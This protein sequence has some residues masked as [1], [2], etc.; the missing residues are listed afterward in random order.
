MKKLFLLAQILLISFSVWSQYIYT[1]F[2]GNEPVVFSG[3]PNS[4]IK[5]ANPNPSGIN[6]SANA[7]KWIRTGE[8]WAHVY[9]DLAGPIDFTTGT[10]FKLK[11][12]SPIPCN[13]LF[14]LE[15]TIAPVEI[16][17]SVSIPNQ[18][19]QLSYDFTGAPSGVYNKIVIFFDFATT[20][21]NT[22]YFDDI[23]G[24]EFEGATVPKPYLALDVQDN[25]ENN[26]W[27]SITEW[28]FQDPSLISLPVVADP[29]LPPNHVVDYDR[30]GAFLYTNAQCVL[31][32]RM[33]LTTRS[34]F[35]LKVFFPSSNNYSGPLTPTAALKLQN[36]LLGGNAWTTQEE[37][38]LPV[39]NF[40]QW[41]TL[42]FDFGYA[43]ARDDLDQV[44]IQLGGEGHNV[45]GQFYFD[46]FEL[47]GSPFTINFV[48]EN[49]SLNV[50]VAISPTIAFSVPVE[51]A[52]GN[53][54]TNSNI[55]SII[56]F[57]VN[58][59]GGANVP[60][61]GTVD[62]QKKVITINPNSDLSNNQT[63]YL[64]LNNEV[65]RYQ[66]GN[67][68]TGESIVF[69]TVSSTQLYLYDNFDDP[70]L[71]TWGYWD[72]NAG[73]I[74]DINANNPNVFSPLNTTATVAKYTKASGSDPYTHAFAIL[75]GKLDLSTNHLFQTMVYSENAGSVF[76]VKL[77]NN[78]LPE[79]WITEVTA[80]YTIQTSNTWEVANFD[81]SSYAD[82][83]DLDKLLLMINPGQTGVG[84][85]YFD[86]LYGPSFTLPAVSPV[87]LD[88]HI[89]NNGS[90]IEIHFD[91]AMEP[92]PLNSGN[93]NVSVDGI[94]NFVNSTYRK[95]EDHSI[96][97]LNLSSPVE[98]GNTVLLSYLISGTITSLDNGILQAFS[99]YPVFNDLSLKLN[100]TVFLEGPFNNTE[101]ST[102]LN[103]S[104]LPLNQ[105]Y[106][107]AP[108][109]YT[110]NESVAVIPSPDIVDWILIELRDAT[111][112][113]LAT[114]GK[115]IARQ[116]AFLLKNGAVVDLD[117]NTNLLIFDA[118][119]QYGLYVVVWHR[120]HIGILS[121]FQV[122]ASNGIYSYNFG[123]GTNQSFGNTQKEIG[124]N[125]WGMVAGNGLADFRIDDLDQTEV[126]ESQAGE[127]GYLQGDY[128]MDSQVNNKDKDDFW[129]TNFGAG[130]SDYQLIWEDNFDTNGA[131]DPNKWSYDFGTGANGWGNGELQYYTSLPQNVKVENGRL[132][133]T[134]RHESYAGSNYTSGRIKTQGK[135][136][137]QYGRVDIKT[138]LP[139]GQGIWPANWMLGE[140]FSTIGWP[141]C[142]EIDIMEYR[143][144]DPNIIH[145]AIHTPSS[146][147][148]TINHATT[149]IPNVENEFHIYSIEWDETKIRFLVDN[150][151]FY[152]YQPTV[153]NSSTWPF[154]ANLFLLLNL[155]VGGSFGGSVNNAIFPQTMEIDYIKV[156]Q[157]INN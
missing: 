94:M 153:Y 86:E 18:W 116:A 99:N 130:G 69:S 71:L 118:S 63:Y 50:P 29:I 45:P 137:F 122:I 77:Q 3:Y 43:Y 123:S 126:W 124:A 138:K 9:K 108:W 64:A 88:A 24:P 74:L 37:I 44:V 104:K 72:N 30:S 23:E 106:S 84:V 14:K 48:P 100:L 128:N 53:A 157:R 150:V 51:M 109:N 136:S 57:K 56:T 59:D 127:S 33:N 8:Q 60:Y 22:F 146:Y 4:P 83:T 92:E 32:H 134:T 112:A 120:N 148:G 114:S 111:E 144:A 98:P 154:D 61:T 25:F 117:G 67:L 113:S 132:L 21:S 96:I 19:K 155:A 75:G 42:S 76:A 27:G 40:N 125:I 95:A 58:N 11:V 47:L 34:T 110:G 145:G 16:M 149:F 152:V 141:A 139:G 1:D 12:Y 142:G 62:D 101:M 38:V 81:F 135:F 10:T 35:E 41:I 87:V 70:A 73:G 129:Y 79:P 68:I 97:V 147:G 115:V 52:N 140:S 80:G 89:I 91:K 36:S 119:L 107:G 13:I 49:G 5:V 105:P 103:P 78:D 39:V 121:A 66:G 65:I 82:R 143:G 31:D 28:F 17:G 151:Q 90:A 102:L 46:D 7:G 15:G 26:G 133:I 2:D 156:Y 20:V 55:Q 85:H 93:L 54:I 6:T 131:P